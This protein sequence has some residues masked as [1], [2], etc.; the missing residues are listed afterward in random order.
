MFSSKISTGGA[1]FRGK[2]YYR[3]N[4]RLVTKYHSNK[5]VQYP[6][7]NKFLTHFQ[8]I[9]STFACNTTHKCALLLLRTTDF[10]EKYLY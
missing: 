2:N 6:P 5:H 9:M 8:A 10:I 7:E 4:L 1:D 3:H